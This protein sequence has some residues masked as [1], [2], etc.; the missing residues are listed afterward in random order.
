MDYAISDNKSFC[1]F[2]IYPSAE[3]DFILTVYM[4]VVKMSIKNFSICILTNLA[5]FVVR[6][7]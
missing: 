2:T 5:L 4:Y 3:S 7:A 6:N 1:L